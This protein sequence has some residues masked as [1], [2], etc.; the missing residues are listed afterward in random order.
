M[1]LFFRGPVHIEI[2]NAFYRFYP[3]ITCIYTDPYMTIMKS[4]VI[5]DYQYVHVP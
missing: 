1:V 2:G 3:K 4:E 5:Y